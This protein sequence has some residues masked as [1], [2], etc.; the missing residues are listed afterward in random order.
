MEGSL[1]RFGPEQWGLIYLKTLPLA[2]GVPAGSLLTSNCEAAL[3]TGTLFFFK[4]HLNFF[5]LKCFY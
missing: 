2:P 4:R 5:I 1:V 3:I